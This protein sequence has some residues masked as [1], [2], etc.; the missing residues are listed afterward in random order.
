MIALYFYRPILRTTRFFPTE[1]VAREE[2]ELA[3][4]KATVRVSTGRLLQDTDLKP[5][6]RI[7]TGIPTRRMM[8]E[9]MPQDKTYSCYRDSSTMRLHGCRLIAGHP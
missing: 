6:N 8:L 5:L 9:P 4:H 2:R 1:P 3:R 7:E